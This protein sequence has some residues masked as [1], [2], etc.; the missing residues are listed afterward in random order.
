MERNYYARCGSDI[1]NVVI[2]H[3]DIEMYRIFI[4][5]NMVIDYGDIEMFRIVI[6]DNK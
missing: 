6:F 4:H 3:D 1:D 2:D 5:D